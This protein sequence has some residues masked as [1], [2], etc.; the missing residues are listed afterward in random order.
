MHETAID[1]DRNIELDIFV[2][3]N[4][5]QFKSLTVSY[6]QTVR[7]NYLETY[8]AI[9]GRW[10]DANDTRSCTRIWGLSIISF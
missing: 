1:G 4:V 2:Y 9:F 3:N 8:M 6:V 7:T 5:E 10:D